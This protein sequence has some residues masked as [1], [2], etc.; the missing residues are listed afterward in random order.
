METVHRIPSYTHVWDQD[1][2]FRAWEAQI[3]ISLAPENDERNGL[4][5][6][7]EVK[8]LKNRLGEIRSSRL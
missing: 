5:G 8:K 1:S 6:G 2:D 7:Q 4:R 3:A